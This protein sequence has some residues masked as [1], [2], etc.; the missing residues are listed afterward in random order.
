MT[1]SHQI[2]QVKQDLATLYHIHHNQNFQDCYNICFGSAFERGSDTS[3]QASQ[4]ALVSDISKKALFIST[5]KFEYGEP[6]KFHDQ[7][8]NPLKARQV[9]DWKA[10]SNNLFAGTDISAETV[11]QTILLLQNEVNRLEKVWPP[12]PSSRVLN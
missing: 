11:R 12:L 6:I 1:I 10:A 5:A 3:Y 2:Q 7:S 8:G 4:N 9:Q